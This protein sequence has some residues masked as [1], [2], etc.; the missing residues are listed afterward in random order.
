MGRRDVVRGSGQD[1]CPIEPG[2]DPLR[3]IDRPLD[4]LPGPGGR[5]G[6]EQAGA[7]RR[8][9]RARPVGKVPLAQHRVGADPCGQF[10]PET[11]LDLG[12]GDALGLKLPRQISHSRSQVHLGIPVRRQ[13]VDDRLGG[14]QRTG[15]GQ[16]G[17]LHGRSVGRPGDW[18]SGRSSAQRIGGTLPAP[19]PAATGGQMPTIAMIGAGS[20][21]FAQRLTT[22]ILSYPE[23]ADSTLRLMDLDPD[24]LTSIGALAR[25][26]VRE[27]NLPARIETTTDRRKALDGADYVIVAI[28]VGGV[29]AVRPD[30]EIPHRYGVDQAVGDT[31]G[32]GGVFRALRTIPVL[33]DICRDMEELCPNAL[34]INYS[35]PMAVNCWA[36]GQATRIKVIGF[37]HSVQGTSRQLAGY[38]GVPYAEVSYWV[39]GINHMAWFLE[40]RRGDEDLRPRLFQAM[41][42]PA[43]YEKDR[44]RFEVMRH[45]G[46]FVTES[47]RHMSE[48]VPY[49]RRTQTLAE[50]YAPPWRRD[51]DLYVQRQQSYYE[52]VQRQVDGLDPIP[53]DRTDEYCATVLHAIETNTPA[54]VNGNVINRGLIANLPEGA[55]VEVPCLVD[56]R[57]I[58]P[59]AVGNLPP[60]LAALN[61]S[62]IA[63]QELAVKAAVE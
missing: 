9:A 57:G 43:I 25:R 34:L 23:L 1:D 5:P 49:F 26:L 15:A 35:N 59:C 48:Y 63:V 55:C 4:L 10:L 13:R 46:Y 22:D 20:V 42:D 24:R 8:H 51:Y 56:A 37:C 21:V 11:G 6:E 60:Q 61:R 12:T 16:E 54:R 14:V 27:R 50:R 19:P 62:N 36:I 7:P 52:G 28:Q 41:A 18:D 45:F 30:V 29:D 53:T 2:Q 58:H 3:S 38:I 44:V 31:L 39:A 17:R 32:P 40:F 33:I 47:T